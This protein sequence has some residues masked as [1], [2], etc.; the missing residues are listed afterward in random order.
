MK[1]TN[2]YYGHSAHLTTCGA[3]LPSLSVCGFPRHARKHEYIGATD[4]GCIINKYISV[5]GCLAWLFL[6]LHAIICVGRITRNILREFGEVRDDLRVRLICMRPGIII[7]R[8]IRLLGTELCTT[9]TSRVSDVERRGAVVRPVSR[10]TSPPVGWNT[11]LSPPLDRM[12]LFFLKGGGD[13]IWTRRVALS[14]PA[15]NQRVIRCGLQR[16]GRELGHQQQQHIQPD[17]LQSAR[18]AAVSDV[19][20]GFRWII[21][22][23]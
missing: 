23:K 6:G 5:C 3:P 15:L 7:I 10:G 2:K 14:R 22:T 4:L 17:A 8:M 11:F 19:N 13:T 1:Y 12:C 20:G 9:N 21:V 18:V 16:I